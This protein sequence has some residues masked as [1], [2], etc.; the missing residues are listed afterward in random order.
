MSKKRGNQEHQ[1]EEEKQERKSKAKLTIEHILQ[2]IK[3][4]FRTNA[5]EDL[6]VLIEK[7]EITLCSGPAGTGKSHISVAKAI[8]LLLNP[9]NK[10]EKIIIIKPVVE[11]DEKLGFL[12]GD[13]DEKL[14][15]YKYSTINIFEKMIGKNKVAQLIDNGYVEAMALA[16]L[17]G[18]NID[19][20]I[21]IFEEAQNSTPRQIK[22]L[23][24]RIGENAK[25]IINGDLEQNDRYD[26]KEKT[27]LFIAMQK[28]NGINGIGLFEFKNEDIV[29]NQLIGKILDRFNGDI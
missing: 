13:I 5:Q 22:T 4:K 16:Y 2:P 3:L 7:N 21:L 24:T 19:N 26:K 27:G 25:F 12:P 28:L 14:A 6:W 1:N 10:F 29:R 20:A 18:V 23:L 17:R 15:P 8:D 11:A 9:N